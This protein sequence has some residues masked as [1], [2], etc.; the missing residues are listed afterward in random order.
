MTAVTQDVRVAGKSAADSNAAVRARYR[1]ERR[2]QWYGLAAIAFAGLMLVV[3]LA[4]VFI[5]GF[6]AFTHHRLDLEVPITAEDL[7]VGELRRAGAEGAAGRV[8]RHLRSLRAPGA[9]RPPQQRLRGR[10][11]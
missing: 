1:A 4:D 6:P 7:D 8:R 3:L 10:T 5:K 9:Q 11:A 2:F